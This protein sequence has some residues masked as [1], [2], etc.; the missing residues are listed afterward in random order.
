MA[1][2]RPGVK[3]LSEPMMVW[4]PTHK[5]VIRPQWV[6]GGI[7]VFLK[8][9]ICHNYTIDRQGKGMPR[10]C[11]IALHRVMR[12]VINFPFCKYLI[13]AVNSLMSRQ[14]R[15]H[16]ADD[17][18]KCNF[19][20]ENV[21][22]LIQISLKFVPK[23]PINN[24]S[25]LVQIMAWRRPGDKPLSEPMMVN[26]PTHICVTRPQWV[27]SWLSSHTQPMMKSWHEN[28]FHITGPLCG[29]SNNHPWASSQRA[30]S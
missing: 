14:N 10:T 29:E 15:R 11:M 4:L 12:I 1:W 17:V 21:W 3:P 13:S 26:L 28:A 22:I 18:F 27:N 5:C 20:N 24:I 2:R 23:G 8:I 19:L 30:S 9:F 7:Y 25:A 16:F 6:K